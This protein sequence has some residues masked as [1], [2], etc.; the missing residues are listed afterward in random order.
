MAD[1]KTLV[2]E[3]T[4]DPLGRGYAGMTDQEVVD[5]LNAADRSRNKQAITG[6]DAFQATD[7][8]EWG[9]LSDPQRSQWL[10]F[11]GRQ[12]ID[13]FGSANVAFVQSI[14]GGG[15]QTVQS[16][17]ALRLEAISRA[18]ELGYPGRVRLGH[19]ERARA[20]MGG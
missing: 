19:V 18:E 12:T 10:A 5:S 1:I 11:C 13:P 15:S 17:A 20:L 9:T 4:N 7:A 8:A 6:D 2:D 14:F 16:L 3:L